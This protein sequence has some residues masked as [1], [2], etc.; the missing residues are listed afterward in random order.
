MRVVLSI[1]GWISCGGTMLLLWWDRSV[2]VPQPTGNLKSPDTNG[3]NHQHKE[4]NF[5]SDPLMLLVK[6]QMIRN[7]AS[8][9]LSLKRPYSHT[10][11]VAAKIN[12]T[13]H[14]PCQSLNFKLF[15]NLTLLERENYVCQPAPVGQS[16]VW[17][18]A[19]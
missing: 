8:C 16:Q 17:P 5:C 7:K 2:P 14:S 6:K 12:L 11:L 15:L 19:Q 13:R 10:N 9:I 1:G 3:V 18:G 4:R